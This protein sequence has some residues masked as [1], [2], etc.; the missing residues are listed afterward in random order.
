MWKHA[1][2]H[3]ATSA[4]RYTGAEPAAAG[5]GRDMP[6]AACSCWARQGHACGSLQHR[7]PC[8]ARWLQPC[9]PAALLPRPALHCPAPKN[10]STCLQDER[11]RLALDGRGQAVALAPNRL[12]HALT[13]SQRV[14]GKVWGNMHHLAQ[15]GWQLVPAPA[16]SISCLASA[17][18]QTEPGG[19]PT[20]A[21]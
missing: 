15:P 7:P 21:S 13:E 19:E 1:C 18:G 20:A 6:A 12:E 10:G 2:M 16:C 8:C 5:H 3:A 9:C 4:N 11:Q 17:E 14:C